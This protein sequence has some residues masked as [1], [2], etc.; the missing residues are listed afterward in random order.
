MDRRKVLHTLMWTTLASACG[1]STPEPEAPEP[2]ETALRDAH[3]IAAR[4][5]DA[6]VTMIVF[7]DRVRKHAL[8]PKI[9][10]LDVIGEAFEGTDVDPVEDV[11]RAFIAAQSA[12]S[13]QDAMAVAEHHVEP[14]R[15]KRAMTQLVEKSG[16]EGRWLV[17]YPFPAAQV[18]VRKKKTVVLAV[19]PK[20]LVVTSPKHA[21]KA[22]PLQ[23]SGGIPDPSNR[24]A[25]VA[26]ANQPSKTLKAPGAPPVP[27]SVH[28]IYAEVTLR[29]DGG[30]DLKID[31]E[32]SD[33]DQAARDAAQLT[34]DIEKAST[35]NL[36][37]IR[38]Q[39]VGTI[40]FTSEGKMVR[41][42][43]RVSRSELDTL[44][45]IASM[46]LG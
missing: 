38:Y 13:S 26:D 12:R 34:A 35:V 44:L 30:A 43:R 2:S 4:A 29:D 23:Q 46:M 8:A 18:L 33:D 25:I 39:P 24:A 6:K 14:E 3:A 41:A 10:R 37:V 5:V 9:G 28:H 36:G 16:D 11:D 21:R 32:S 40:Q 31:G 19:Q 20:L 17:G 45:S 7:M 27:D 42:R 22:I 15:I 1:P